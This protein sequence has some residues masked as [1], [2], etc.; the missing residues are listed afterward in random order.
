MRYEIQVR[1]AIGLKIEMLNKRGPEGPFLL[2]QKHERGGDVFHQVPATPPLRPRRERE[3]EREGG[4][5]R[6]RGMEIGVR[7]RL[8]S[9][10]WPPLAP[11]AVPHPIV[12][13]KE[14][15]RARLENQTLRT[16]NRQ[17]QH[18]AATVGGWSRRWPPW[19]LLEKRRPTAAAT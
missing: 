11:P 3:G 12:E 17:H 1:L 13:S 8:A 7:R 15:D 16:R 10:G 14:R 18:A 9:A 2:Q 6:G 5:G 19:Q 4:R